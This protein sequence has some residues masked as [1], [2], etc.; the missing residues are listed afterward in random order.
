MSNFLIRLLII[1]AVTALTACGS[2]KLNPINNNSIILAFGDSLTQGVGVKT[3]NSYPKIL[4][5]LS[6]LNVINSGVSGETTDIGLKRL[7]TEL[8][9]YN[10]GLLLLLEGGN[11]I[12]RNRDHSQIKKNLN[13][14]IMVAKN[15]GVQVVLIGVP[16]KKLFS[17][18]ASIYRELAEE[19]DLVFEGELIGSLMRSLSMKSDSIHFN[20]SGYRKMAESIYELLKENGALE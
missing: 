9:K 14:M 7:P 8:E 19:H 2:P 4:S 5:E 13:N 1:V 12:L 15:Y 3:E 6:G 20:K 11:D 16:E 18:S 17:S 10:P